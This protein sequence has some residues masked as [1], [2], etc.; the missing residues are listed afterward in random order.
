MAVPTEC[1]SQNLLLKMLP[2]VVFCCFLLINTIHFASESNVFPSAKKNREL[3]E[4]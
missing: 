1:G 3:Q 2:C 4:I